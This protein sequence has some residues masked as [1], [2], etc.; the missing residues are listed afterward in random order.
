MRLTYHVMPAAFLLLVAFGTSSLRA[1]NGCGCESTC[2]GP[3]MPQACAPCCFRPHFFCHRCCAPPQGMVVQSQAVMGQTFV[4]FQQVVS[5]PVMQQTFAVAQPQTYQLVA[6]TAQP[7]VLNLQL[8]AAQT[9]SQAQTSSLSDLDKRAI[10]LALLAQRM[11]GS[12]QQA[13]EQSEDD[14]CQA[15]RNAKSADEKFEA[16][17]EE[18]RKLRQEVKALQRN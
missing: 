11:N 3:A 1:G 12:Q 6:Q 5:Q 8:P 10:M 15:V 9:Q 17:C 14:T 4:P 2:A 18:L 7:A 16:L 13:L